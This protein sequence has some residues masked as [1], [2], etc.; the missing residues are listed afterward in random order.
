[1][2]EINFFT[3][4]HYGIEA[5]TNKQKAIENVDNYFHLGGKKAVVI[6]SSQN[7][8]E[9]IVLSKSKF[10]ASSFFK[11]VGIA[12]SYFTV[13]IPLSML[14][15]KAILRSGKKY[16][17][18]DPKQELE[19]GIGLSDA[20]I[21]KI[22]DM[23]PKIKQQA[24]NP[25]IEYLSGSKVFRLK[26]HPNYIFKVGIADGRQVLKNRQLFNDK[27]AMEERFKNM[28]HAKR[29]CLVDK[30]DLL[31]VPHAKK[32]D[33]KTPDGKEGV[34]IVEERM[35]ISHSDKD[36]EELYYRHSKNLNGTARQLATFIAKTGFN[37]VAPRNIPIINED[38]GYNGSPRIALIDLEDM[39]SAVNGFKGDINGSCGL[40]GCV[41]KEQIDIVL[42]EAKKQGI[43]TSRS[44]IQDAKQRRLQKIESE[45]KLYEFY[46]K[47]GI[48][49]GAEPIQV[50][51]DN[52]GLDLSETAKVT[53]FTDYPD[54]KP[55]LKKIEVSL[56]KAVEDVVEE[57]NQ[58]IQANSKRND[59]IKG[60]R[61]MLLNIHEPPFQG[62]N[63]VG[64]PED[65]MHATKEDMNKFW[66]RKIINALIDKGYIYK[67]ENVNGHGYFIQA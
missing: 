48:A 54:G 16:T 12:L 46:A 34:M 2:S 38:K 58:N 52:L 15:T 32:F 67:L 19:K 1:M 40:I 22:Q 55:G 56:R 59:G 29:I 49:T 43:D 45:T 62:Y 27:Q 61:Y 63:S 60:K 18:I 26:E 24:Q 28:V 10:T 35:N 25:D 17:L 53:F 21:K 36:Q 20:T 11:A 57:I 30:L 41:S 8:A 4:V 47:N 65:Q 7:G 3:P 37:D 33:F 44:D 31:H 50:D 13:I 6:R 51:I 14:I 23:L 5:K 42:K 66:L 64:L 9:N 39:D